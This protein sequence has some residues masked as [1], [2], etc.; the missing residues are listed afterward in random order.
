MFNLKKINII[1]KNKEFKKVYKYGKSYADK[2]L[3]FFILKNKK[4][5]TRFGI[6]TAKKINKAVVRNKIR[7]RLKEI[8]RKNLHSINSNYDVVVM[9]R[10]RGMES[11]YKDLENSFIKLAKK[12]KIYLGDEN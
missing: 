1:K 9:C 5:T 10:V 8:V 2:N 4:D 11:S 12:T 6:T 7:R 3:V